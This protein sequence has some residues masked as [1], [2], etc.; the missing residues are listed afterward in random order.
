MVDERPVLVV[1]DDED[2]RDIL[3]VLLETEGFRVETAKDGVEA[4]ERLKACS[5]PSVILL[6]MMMPRMD[7]EGFVHAMR[8]DP[9][10]ADIP[11]IIMSGHNA[12]RDKAA[13]LSAVACLAKPVEIDE[14]LQ[15]VRKIAS[16]A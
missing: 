5:P 9:A 15:V 14:I 7:G 8:R 11:V 3:R 12:A 13:A 1:D 16:S 6:D 10:V 2:V 4:L